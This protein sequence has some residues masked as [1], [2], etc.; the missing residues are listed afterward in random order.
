MEK[1]YYFVG[2]ELKL[3]LDI[4]CEG[5]TMD[6]DPW[7]AVFSKGQKSI[8]C[9][10]EHNSV[11]RDGQWYVLV[12]TGVIGK[13]QYELTVEIDVPDPDFSDGYRHETWR[14]MVIS[15]R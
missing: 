9:D 6:D 4:D 10:A 7:K 11:K 15:V 3:A 5:F 14:K 2:T 1:E 13:G 8:V 12:D